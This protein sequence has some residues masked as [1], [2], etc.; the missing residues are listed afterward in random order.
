MWPCPAF[1]GRLVEEWDSAY[2]AAVKYCAF[3][4]P[5][6][7]TVA[8]LCAV[9]AVGLQI[10][11]NY[12]NDYADGMRG[13][14]AG[15]DGDAVGPRRLVASGANPNHVLL[16]A[17]IAAM[18]ACAAGLAA[19]LL[20][21]RWWLIA[22]G[23][24]CLLAAWGYTN[25]RRPYGYRGLGE[26]AAFIFFGLVPTLGTQYALSGSVTVTGVAGSMICG[27]LSV[28]VMMVNNLRDLNDDAAHGKCTLMV[29][30]GEESGKRWHARVMRWAAALTVIFAMPVL[31]YFMLLDWLIVLPAEVDAERACAE[32]GGNCSSWTWGAAELVSIAVVI[33]IVCCIVL[34]LHAIAAVRRAQWRRAL[35]LCS[36][37]ALVTACAF[38]FNAWQASFM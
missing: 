17:G 20:T 32:Y 27:L 11:V 38:V 16:A 18:I 23:A 21:K 35:P 5:W 6:F 25:G 9:V 2:I 4:W 28:S 12:L 7:V 19:V 14:D 37:T 30:I 10:A 3:S 8:V 31:V 24:V 22:L 29:R 36:M 1:P 15:R 33:C 34:T 26:V 13:T